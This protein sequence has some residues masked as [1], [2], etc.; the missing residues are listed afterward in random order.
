MATSPGDITALLG[1]WSDGDRDAFGRLVSLAYDDLRAIAHRRL[2]GQGDGGGELDTTGLVHEVFLRL[3]GRDVARDDWESRAH[4]YG[5]ASRAMRTILV[6]HARRIR[7]PRRGGDQVRLPLDEDTVTGPDAAADLL[8]VDE[9]IDRL[10]G[11]HPRMAEIVE[12]RFF[13][14]FSVAETAKVLGTSVRTVEREWT[15]ARAYLLE[16]LKEPGDSP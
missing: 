9:A 13:G 15:R 10:A 12:L 8:D 6:D 16:S 3:V 7:A 5:F 11:H 2:A 1:K 4:F 14:G